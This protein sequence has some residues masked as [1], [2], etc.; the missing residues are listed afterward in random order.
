MVDALTAK[1]ID[2]GELCTTQPDIAQNGWV[3][4]RDDKHSQPAD[5]LVPL[6]RNDYLAK[7]DA[8][9]FEQILNDVSAKLT[10]DG[11]ARH[12]TSSTPS[13]SRTSRSSRRRGCSRT[14]SSSRFG[15]AAAAPRHETRNNVAVTDFGG[16]HVA[17]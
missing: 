1:T 7:V 12:S 17:S 9:A 15:H 16:R 11:A 10:T 2:L 13:T 5:N 4:L 14:A 6:V 8:T 3:L